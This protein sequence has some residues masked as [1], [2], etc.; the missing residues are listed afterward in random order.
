MTAQ[1]WVTRAS[2]LRLV[3]AAGA[4]LLCWAGRLAL[5]QQGPLLVPE[6]VELHPSARAAINAAWLTEAERRPLRVFHGVWGQR[7]LDTPLAR[8]VVALNAWD[9]DHPAL[10]DESVAAE[11]RAE[12]ELRQG[13]LRQALAL[14]KGIESNRAARI[15]AEAYEGLGDHDAADLAVEAPVRQLLEL[16]FEDPAELTEAVGAMIVRARLRGQPAHDYQVMMTLLSRAHQDLD[17]LYWPAKLTEARLL[18]E[19]D[20]EKEA[21][22][23]L[24]ETLELNPRCAEAWFMLGRIALKR[25]DFASVRHAADKLRQLNGQHPLAEVLL[26]ESRLIQ[27]DPDGAMDLLLPLVG[28]LA[29]LRPALALV[30]ASEALRYDESAMHEA[31]D[32]YERLSPGSAVPYFIV[33][34]HLTVNRQYEAAAEML[35][36]A[37]RRQ[38]AWPAPQ[39]EL[40]LMELQDGHDDKALAVLET[41]VELDPFNKRAVNSL[42]LLQELAGYERIESEHFVIRYKPGIDE[43]TAQMMPEPLEQ[44]HR[45]VSARFGHETNRKTIIELLPDHER[46]AVRVTG[47]PWIHTIAAS[48]G[49]VIA[50]EVPRE[51]LPSKHQGPFDWLRVIRHEYTHTI[52]LSQTRNRIPHW[53]TEAAAVSMEN[54]PRDYETCRRLADAYESSTLFDL[55]RIKWAFVRPQRPGDRALAYAQ[56]HWMVQYLDQRYGESALVR[57]LGLYFDGVREQQA[58]LEALAVTRDQFFEDFLPWAGE[59]VKQWG[60]APQP[61]LE[62]LEDEVRWAD[63]DLAAAMAASGQARLDAI[64]DTLTEGIGRPGGSRSRP[65]TAD[66]WPKLIRPRVDIDGATLAA[67]LEQYPDHP[68]VLEMYLRRR[69]EQTGSPDA[70]LVPWLERYAKA[71][72]VDPFPHRKLAQIWLESDTPTQ[73]IPDLER[74]DRAEQKTPV[75]AVELA[76][77]YRRTGQLDLALAKATRALQ[78]NPY[79]APNRELAAAIAIEAN[80]LELG[81]KHIAALTLIEPDRPQHRKRLAAI[82]RLIEDRHR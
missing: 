15:R 67:W 20:N 53:L 47:M 9:F 81:R 63:P 10:S 13:E 25:F 34:R 37:I 6:H 30:A 57:L 65:F 44:M 77:L 27:D 70:S 4:G 73:A 76:K 68:D 60:L 39:I 41:V 31:L 58:M 28:R 22:I 55:D 62:Q 33:G 75:F 66:R 11:I 54:A 82:D 72:P 23:A 32:R 64:V 5:A 43:V 50:L 29:K 56:G 61:S 19:K 51:G 26:A 49:P 2:N 42:F 79:H 48:T 69:I 18:V 78:I 36:E 16:K 1:R 59:Q 74:L 12:A 52:T 14:A 8:A 80:Q 71:R 35:A 45:E 40:G 46:F 7:D 3:L 21:V 24:H 38:G 17:R